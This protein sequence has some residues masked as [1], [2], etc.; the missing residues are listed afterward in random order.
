MYNT[1]KDKKIRDE[2]IGKNFHCE[3]KRFKIRMKSQ[4]SRIGTDS[5]GH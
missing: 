3:I 4:K 5:L 2:T 1:A